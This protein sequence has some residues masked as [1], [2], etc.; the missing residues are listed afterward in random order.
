MLVPLVDVCTS[1][2]WS[3]SAQ[4]HVDGSLQVAPSLIHDTHVQVYFGDRAVE[5]V[6]A[7]PEFP[8][9][10]DT[11]GMSFTDVGQVD[12]LNTIEVIV[13]FG[14]IRLMQRDDEGL[15]FTCLV[16]LQ[17]HSSFHAFFAHVEV[18]SVGAAIPLLL[19]VAEHF[20]DLSDVFAALVTQDHLRTSL[21]VG[22]DVA[23]LE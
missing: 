13:R 7:S 23:F 2:V 12:S 21:E 16:L 11:L 20:V 17:L 6:K 4:L 19:H 1:W 22:D 18:A 8:A 3:A 10:R 15:L 14:V 5:C 9:A